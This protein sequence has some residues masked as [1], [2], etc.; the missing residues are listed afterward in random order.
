[1]TTELLHP[2]VRASAPIVVRPWNP[3]WAVRFTA[4]ADRLRRTLG[5]TGRG[6]AMD[7][8]HIGSTAVQTLAG[9]DTI[10]MLLITPDLATF[11]PRRSMLT[12]L[13]YRSL[14]DGG[15]S[16]Q[17]KLLLGPDHDLKVALH[18]YQPGNTTALHHLLVRD[19]LRSRP[20]ERISYSTLKQQLAARQPADV[21]AYTNGKRQRLTQ[22]LDRA[23]G[24]R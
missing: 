19:L 1:M 23:T 5:T 14:G 9:T 13:G 10:D 20:D 18:V 16:S 4:E 21:D 12:Q 17:R 11:D 15:L 7:I 8:Q 24:R 2:D 6:G 3:Q 22:L